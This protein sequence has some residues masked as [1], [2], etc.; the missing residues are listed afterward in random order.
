[1]IV[2]F[3]AM[4]L[5]FGEF[6][7]F[8]M[9]M[10]M[11][12]SMSAASFVVTII[13]I[14]FYTYI[15]TYIIIVVATA[16]IIVTSSASLMSRRRRGTNALKLNIKSGMFNGILKQSYLECNNCNEYYK[17]LHLFIGNLLVNRMKLSDKFSAKCSPFI[18]KKLLNFFI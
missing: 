3:L 17:T 10:I 18:S 1:M 12:M 15:F 13:I 2:M 4:C 11:S 14:I 7:L 9:N 8:I 5:M 6:G 16:I